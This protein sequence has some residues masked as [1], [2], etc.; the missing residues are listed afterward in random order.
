[1]DTPQRVVRRELRKNNTEEVFETPA[2]K[3]RGLRSYASFPALQTDGTL[4][5]SDEAATPTP[6]PAVRLR[7][8]VGGD[9]LLGC[10]TP[11]RGTSAGSAS[12][13]PSPFHPTRTTQRRLTFSP[14]AALFTP[15]ATKLVRPD[16][17]V[18]TSTGLQS[19]RQQARTRTETPSKTPVQESGLGKHRASTDSLRRTRKKPHVGPE[20]TPCR[21]R[22]NTLVDERP[23]PGFRLEPRGL[24]PV[25]APQHQQLLQSLDAE[26]ERRSARWSWGGSDAASVSSA[27]TLAAPGSPDARKSRAKPGALFE[28]R[29]AMDVEFG[30][31]DDED[32]VFRARS[33]R[34]DAVERPQMPQI[35]Q[36]CAT[37]YPHFLTRSYFERA[38]H[39]LPF[40]APNDELRVD[41]LGYLDYFE[42][43]F[44][45]LGRA[46]EGNFS[47]VFSARSLDDGLVYAV[48]RTRRPYAGRA[49]R[50]RRL[51]E[52]EI[53]WALPPTPGIVRL[54]DAWEQFGHL[55]MQFEL[56]ERGSMAE[57]L[58]D[59]A[60]SQIPIP[61]QRAWAVLAHAS[62][63]LTLVHARGIAHL[64]LKP[65]NFLLGPDFDTQG[66][67]LADGWLKL[68]DFG[69]A[70]RLPRE[71]LAWVEE[72]DRQYMAPEVLRGEYTAA[73]DVFSLGMMMLEIIADIILPENGDD[74]HKLREGC[75]DDPSFENLPYSAD[76]LELVK[77]MLHPQPS[78]RPTMAQLA[79]LEQCQLAGD[80]PAASEDE[81]DSFVPL[82]RHHSF[83]Y[84]RPP[85]PALLRSATAAEIQQPSHP[86]VTRSAAKASSEGTGLMRRSGSAPGTATLSNAAATTTAH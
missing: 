5:S 14:A 50:A 49:E 64:D 83:T 71:P 38:G 79:A 31:S 2:A 40:L 13:S 53:L 78:Q 36:G 19:K 44:E 68:A 73:A 76:L 35:V 30:D 81:E 51:R 52:V 11:T 16:P 84:T 75:F 67:E 57:Y 22:Q 45:V 43:H 26:P 54:A 47:T 4:S 85:R 20:E 46:G 23:P 60:A 56:C 10:L 25:L 41:G 8:R 1:M 72:G 58:D 42:Q 66:A 65:A 48:K 62:R 59:C 61:E 21:R 29:D 9:G 24:P 70:A 86:M 15:P 77:L 17:R 39:A 55:Y 37:N 33:P 82:Q 69:H 28:H 32:D 74:W 27:A 18:F 7:G 12:P 34:I 6:T 80:T 3:Q 63:A